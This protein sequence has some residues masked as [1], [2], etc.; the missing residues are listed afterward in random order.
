MTVSIG[1]SER[2]TDHIEN[3][4]ALIKVSDE[5][6]YKSKADGRNRVTAGL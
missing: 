1:C 4:I 6:L 5:R 3:E 2:T